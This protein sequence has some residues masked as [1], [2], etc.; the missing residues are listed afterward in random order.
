MNKILVTGAAGFIGFHVSRRLLERGDEV[1]GI[2]NLNS[3]YDV[4][5]KEARLEELEPFGQFRF[6]RMDLADRE[7]MED[8]FAIEKFDYVVN[9]AA[10]AGVRYSLQNPHAYIDSNIQGFINI[11]EGCRHNH[12]GHLVYASSSSVYGA[13]ETMPFSVHDNVDHPLSL[14]AAT[15]KANELMAHTYS[16]LYQIPTTGL[17]FFTV[18]GP[19]G[20]PDMA[21]FLFTK[22]IVEGKPIKVFNYGKHRRDFTFIDDITEGVIRTL[23][24]VAAPNPEWSGLSPDP[25]SSRAPWRV[26]NIGNSK[27]VNLMDYIDALE[28]ELGKTA[29]KEFLPMQPGDVPDTYADVDQLIQ[30]VDYQPK[31]PVAEGIGRFVEWYRGYYGCSV[32][33]D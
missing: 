13:N 1:V 25:G 14:Y 22:A 30:D 17:R 16:H 28:R 15:K 31:T 8:L 6:I 18:Y 27:P 32:P 10:Q 23:D 21:L 9:L 7:A 4:A 5:L 24:H 29:E 19:W 33:G 2:D 26:Y 11:L 3:Y 20:R 12:V